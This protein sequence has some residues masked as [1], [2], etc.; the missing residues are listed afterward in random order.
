MKWRY[1]DVWVHYAPELDGGGSFLARPFLA[2][3]RRAGRARYGR[4]F[5]WCAGP[6]FIGVTLL[7]AG[8]VSDL[9]LADNNPRVAP[10]VDRT[11]DS[12]RLALTYYQSDNFRDVPAHE[13]FDLVV[14]NPPNYCRLNPEHP[15]Y[16]QRRDDPRPNDRGWRIHQDF[17]A[18]VTAH[19]NPGAELF[20]SEV[21]PF[22]RRIYLGGKDSVAY[23]LR[24][25][26]PMAAF[27]PMIE[28]AGLELK[29][30]KPYFTRG[31]VTLYM[32]RSQAVDL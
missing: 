11:R 2:Y 12:N 17:Y 15:K 4:C 8:L 18:T 32:L 28:A 21:E 24:D 20:I 1:R 22:K 9:V 25:E 3:L 14:A 7:R 23:E 13:R 31:G 27:E 29:S 30:V 16:R 26:P 5:E 6:G 19:L 10:W